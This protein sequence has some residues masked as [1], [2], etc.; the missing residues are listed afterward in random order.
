MKNKQVFI[1]I[2]LLIVI[3]GIFMFTRKNSTNDISMQ[4]N[5]SYTLKSDSSGKAYVANTPNEY[6]FS[7]VDDKGNTVKDFSITHTKLMHVIVARKDLAYFQHVHPDFSPATGVFTLK[8]LTF[9][10][11]GEYRIFADF[12]VAN[13]PIDAMG[14]PATASPTPF[15]DVSVGNI[16]NYVPQPIG[17]EINT[18]TFDGYQVT[19]NTNGTLQAGGESKLTFSLSQNGKPITDLEPYLGELGH[20]VILRKDTLGFIHEHPIENVNSIQTG[21]VDFMID[22]PQSGTYKVFTQF[23]RAGKVFTTDFVV[24]ITQKNGSSE[25]MH[26]INMS[27]MGNS[28]Q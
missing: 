14:M 28:M 10:A 2:V 11:D 23:Q 22:F 15:E 9:P 17:S 20:A 19:L 8:D 5:H 26:G 27:G 18:K 7:I 12:A 4:S 25:S 1:G 6:S 21:N 13:S 16:A 3:V 24:S